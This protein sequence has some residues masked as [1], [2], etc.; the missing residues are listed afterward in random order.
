MEG[1]LLDGEVRCRYV[2]RPQSV[3]SHG[4]NPVIKFNTLVRLGY[5][6]SVFLVLAQAAS[7]E[8]V[9]NFPKP[10]R[11]N[12]VFAVVN[13][14][15]NYADVQFTLYGFDGNPVSSGVVNPVRYRVAP[16]GQL[17]IRANE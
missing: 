15:S 1:Y 11:F 17:S 13:P 5:T 6:L 8:S 14:S 2:L 3:A 16:K 9:L 10:E 4:R 7:A 12:A